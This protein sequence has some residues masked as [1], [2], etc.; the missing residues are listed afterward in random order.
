MNALDVLVHPCN[1]EGFGRVAIEAMAAQRP[2]VGPN[3]GGVAESVIDGETGFLVP[4]GDVDA[5]AQATACLLQDKALRQR[6]GDQAKQYTVA[7]FSLQ[8]HVDQTLSIYRSVV[9]A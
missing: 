3:Q 4:A 9:G 2:V 5:F 8:R 6:L 1:V 7:H